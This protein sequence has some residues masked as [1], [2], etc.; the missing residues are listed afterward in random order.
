MPGWTPIAIILVLVAVLVIV[1]YGVVRGMDALATQPDP[2]ALE[3]E[4]AHER[5]ERGKARGG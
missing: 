5:S 1:W 4:R 2:D 3:Q